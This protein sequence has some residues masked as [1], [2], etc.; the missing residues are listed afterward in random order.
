[1]TI[2]T[3]KEL[4]EELSLELKGITSSCF[5]LKASKNKLG[6]LISKEKHGEIYIQHLS[7]ADGYYAGVE[8]F[9]CEAMEFCIS[10]SPP[11]P[12][13][14]LNL[15]FLSKH[16]LSERDKNFGDEIGGII[17]TP[18][19]QDIKST[20][21]KIQLRLAEFYLSDAEHCITG[22]LSLIDDILAAPDN[23]AF[24]FLAALFCAQ[25]NGLISN[26]DVFQKVL[27]SKKIFGKKQFDLALAHKILD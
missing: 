22:S 25:K 15:S 2:E 7:K 3:R 13:Q 11:Y 14:L 6:L 4:E 27:N 24:P 8:L 26:S 18:A 12:S 16:S 20:A 1:M 23:Y 10:Q 5:D 9:K 19:P 21:E 17:R